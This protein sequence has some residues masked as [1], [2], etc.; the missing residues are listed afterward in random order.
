MSSSPKHT[1]TKIHYHRTIFE[2]QPVHLS[3]RPIFHSLAVRHHAFTCTHGVRQL[4]VGGLELGSNAIV[5]PTGSWVSAV[6]HPGVT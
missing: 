5:S 2:N 1:P 6:F 3:R 4:R